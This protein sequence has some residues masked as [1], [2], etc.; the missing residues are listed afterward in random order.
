VHDARSRRDDVLPEPRQHLRRCLAANATTDDCRQRTAPDLL[1]TQLS[2]IE[3]P[4]N[5]AARPRSARERRVRAA[6]YATQV[7]PVGGLLRAVAFCVPA[8]TVAWSFSNAAQKASGDAA[9][10]Q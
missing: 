5:T 7:W 8:S 10:S 6:L 2:V 4:M 3:S 1:A 9:R